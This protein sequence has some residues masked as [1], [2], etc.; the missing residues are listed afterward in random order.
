MSRLL[1]V[2]RVSLSNY[3]TGTTNPSA[4]TYAK[5]LNLEQQKR[6][7][8][9]WPLH[10]ESAGRKGLRSFQAGVQ[11]YP[12]TGALRKSEHGQRLRG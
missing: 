5:L 6:L 3:E 2:C 9:R 12:G 7:P 11:R 1:N 4:K 10:G 8:Q